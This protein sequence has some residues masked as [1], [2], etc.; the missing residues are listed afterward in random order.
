MSITYRT[1]DFTK[2]GAG[3]GAN[4]TNVQVDDNFWFLYEL[5]VALRVLPRSA[6]WTSSR[7]SSSSGSEI[8]T[9]ATPSSIPG[10]TH[11]GSPHA[12]PSSPPPAT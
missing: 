1:T 8:I 5:I 10:N 12:R 11:E 6:A 4:L 7:A 9:F 2:W 3:Q